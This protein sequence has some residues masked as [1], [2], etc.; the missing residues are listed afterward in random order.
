M[1]KLRDS[2]A[3]ANDIKQTSN[4][5]NEVPSIPK[6]YDNAVDHAQQ[7]I[8]QTSNPTMDPFSNRA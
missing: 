3:D 1:K 2:I 6:C 5:I 4:Y 8:N 7:I